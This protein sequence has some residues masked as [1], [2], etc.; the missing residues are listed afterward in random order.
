MVPALAI[1]MIVLAII[2]KIEVRYPVVQQF[3]ALAYIVAL[4]IL[5]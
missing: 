3:I 4:R 5:D 1:A 2:L